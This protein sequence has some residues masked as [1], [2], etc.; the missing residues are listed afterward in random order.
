MSK[1]SIE[2]TEETWNPIT[3]CFKVSTG[4]KNCYAEVMSKRLQNM[5]PASKE[6]YGGILDERGNFNGVINFSEK[7]L[8]EPLKKKKPTMYF[9]SM[10][11][12]FHENVKWEWINKIFAVMALTPHH[13]Y[14]ILTK[15]PDRM[16]EYLSKLESQT[17]N[18]NYC[19]DSDM[20][21]FIC[22]DKGVAIKEFPKKKDVKDLRVNSNQTT[23]NFI[24]FDGRINFDGIV[25]KD[26]YVDSLLLLPSFPLPNV[27]LGTSVENGN[28]YQRIIDL[29]KVPA[30]VRFLSCEPLLGSLDLTHIEYK[31]FHFNMAV[32]SLNGAIYQE[33]EYDASKGYEFT[34]SV[35]NK[36]DW[37]I[38]GGESGHNARPMHPEWAISIRNQC[39]EV[40][41]PFFFKQWGSYN[42]LGEKVKGGKKEAG[43]FLDG[44]Q[45]L[46]MPNHYE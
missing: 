14:Q 36:I 22:K 37:V 28:Q 32:N 20:Q 33:D 29:L 16:L 27:W 34:G 39:K 43:N 30:A 17:I 8:L 9:L 24:R 12:L 21:G 7:A 35:E 13:T 19:E 2:W 10:S 46:E 40:K 6:K 38:V 23:W 3:G 25:Y 42:E 45:Y 4:C 18:S 1:S 15:R 44:K 11:D 5:N 41:V 31:Q 26:E